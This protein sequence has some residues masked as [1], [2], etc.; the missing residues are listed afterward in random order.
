[1]VADWDGNGRDNIAIFRPSNGQWWIDRPFNAVSVFTFGT[2]TDKLVPG[3]F[4]GDG[5][6]DVALWRPSTGQWFILRSGSPNLYYAVPFGMAGDIPAPGDYDGDGRFDLAV[7]RPSQGTWYVAGS[8]GS[9]I[10]RAFGTNGD[11]PIPNAYVR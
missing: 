7:F 10:V 2:A 9:S 6:A 1:V 3:D 8:T 11:Q 5:V 4:T